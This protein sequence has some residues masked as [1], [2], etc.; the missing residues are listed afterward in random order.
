[1][2]EQAADPAG[3]AI[4]SAPLD[5]RRRVF[6]LAIPALGEQME[7]QTAGQPGTLAIP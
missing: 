2:S 3:G 6:A 4:E 1:M 5:A 7:T